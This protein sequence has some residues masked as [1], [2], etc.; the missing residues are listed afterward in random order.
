L[1]FNPTFR[2]TVDDCLECDFIENKL[3]SSLH[4]S[5]N[6]PILP[7]NSKFNFDFEFSTTNTKL[8]LK[9]LIKDEV[10]DIQQSRSRQRRNSSNSSSSNQQQQND[11]LA[12]SNQ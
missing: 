6:F 2:Y 10:R 8:S 12:S 4:E 7:H 1:L 9:N 11:K 3:S 5:K